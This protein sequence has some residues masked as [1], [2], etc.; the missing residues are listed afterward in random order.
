VRIHLG[1]HFYGAGNLGDDFMLAGFLGALRGLAPHATLT[2][3]VPFP[4][5]PLRARFPTI[6]WLPYENSARA[7]AVAACDVWLGLGGSPFQNAHSRWFIDHLLAD[8]ALCAAHGKP[9]FYLGVGVQTAGELELAD[10]RRLLAQAR[11]V[12]TRDPASAARLAALTPPPARVA[13]GADLAH[14]F[15]RDHPPPPAA[16]GRVTLVP[17]FDYADWP[18]RE[19]FLRAIDTLAAREHRWLAQ[20]TRSLPGAER[21]LHASLPAAEISR[22]P[23]VVPDEIP[24]VSAPTSASSSTTSDLVPDSVSLAAAFARWPSAEWLLT[25]RYHAALAGAWAGSKV[26]I[27]ATNEKLRAAARELSCPVVPPDADAA[28]VARAL[29][30]AQPTS[31]AALA[32]A[33]DRAAAATT[34]FFRS[35]VAPGA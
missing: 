15:F 30:A 17:N 9:M 34:A 24:A 19:N 12:W 28:T 6:E 3:S 2:C 35:A 11:A 14:L 10:T 5:A 23:L 20:E 31:R 7:P 32:A 8:A 26:V 4:L 29:A 18:A 33:A 27:I 16:P 25:A 1:H 13:A 21:A 22:W